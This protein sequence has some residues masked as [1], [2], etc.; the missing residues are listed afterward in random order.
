M[1]DLK[2]A[3]EPLTFFSL[4]KNNQPNHTVKL[5]FKHISSKFCVNQGSLWVCH[6]L[7]ETGL[8]VDYVDDLNII[9]VYYYFKYYL[10]LQSLQWC[11]YTSHAS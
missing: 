6:V 3:V 9:W 1:G 7:E 5:P 8:G 10:A 11:I 2:Y 4:K